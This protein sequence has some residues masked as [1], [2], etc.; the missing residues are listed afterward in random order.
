M[1]TKTKITKKTTPKH[2]AWFYIGI[3][4]IILP[5]LVLGFFGKLFIWDR[6]QDG[7]HMDETY[8]IRHLVLE[9][10]GNL[11]VDAPVD[12]KTGDIYF[13]QAKLYVPAGNTFERRLTYS[14]DEFSGLSV[15][16]K[17]VFSKY[18]VPLYTATNLKDLFAAI[19]KLQACQRGITVAFAESPHE[20]TELKAT[21]DVGNGKTAYLYADIGCADLEN[22][23]NILKELHSY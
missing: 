11:K 8:T 6:F 12:P 5:L 16:N 4:A 19:P 20:G 14:Y 17:M 23:V 15:S 3:A 9:A 13:P 2:K 18:T 7:K 10:A 1:P 21:V 22:T